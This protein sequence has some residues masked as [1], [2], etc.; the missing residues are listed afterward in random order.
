MS[1]Q[2]KIKSFKWDEE[3]DILLKTLR[4]RECTIEDIAKILG[5]KEMVI[6]RRLRVLNLTA[7]RWTPDQDRFLRQNY[8]IMTN[9]ELAKALNVNEVFVKDR[10]SYLG[11][12]HQRG[13]KPKYYNKMRK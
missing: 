9:K 4:G 3:N 13:R 6:H 2:Y 7:N 12:L 11:L 5:C 8:R 1:K 10:R